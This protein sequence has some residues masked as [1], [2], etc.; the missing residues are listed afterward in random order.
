MRRG[1][2]LYEVVLALAIFA[3]AMA[4]IAQVVAT[5][6]RAA[7]QARLQSQAVMLCESKMGEV[8]GGVTP[9]Q[10]ISEATF[11]SDPSLDGW[12]WSLAIQPGPRT[13]VMSVAVS[14]ACRRAGAQVDATFTLTRLVRDL[15]AFGT[16]ET[17]AQQQAQ[18]AQQ[19]LLQQQSG[20]GPQQ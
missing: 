8:V 11:S 13:G 5:G 18:A 19:V 1:I 6:A 3:G 7:L 4:A 9:A 10:P 2:T 20:F 17:Q 15:T 16:S 14:V 12:T